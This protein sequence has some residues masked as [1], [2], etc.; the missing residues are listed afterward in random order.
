VFVTNNLITRI[1]KIFDYNTYFNLKTQNYQL[2][3]VRRLWVK[4]TQG[5]DF[6]E[7]GHVKRVR[8]DTH[9]LH[10]VLFGTSITIIVISSIILLLAL[11]SYLLRNTTFR[12]KKL[13]ERNSTKLLYIIS[14]VLFIIALVTGIVYLAY[15]HGDT[16][17]RKNREKLHTVV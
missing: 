3:A 12:Q 10:E 8:E 5:C 9:A 6:I 4:P 17:L 15:E 1:S 14:F 11:F 16:G 2:L 7:A 13:R